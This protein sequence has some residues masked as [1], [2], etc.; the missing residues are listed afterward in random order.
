MSRR[1]AIGFL[2]ILF[3]TVGIL[4][5]AHFLRPHPI[6]ASP[7]DTQIIVIHMEGS[8]RGTENG[9][10]VPTTSEEQETAQK[11]IQYL[12]S[13]RERYTLRRGIEGGYPADWNCITIM[14]S[15]PDGSSRG[16]LLGPK[17]INADNVGI[18]NES[19]AASGNTSFLASFACDL[20]NPQEIRAF[21]SDVLHLPEGF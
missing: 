20:L 2:C 17:D 8:L 14:L 7:E 11:I 16:V 12:S 10:W 9:T 4:F 13:S 18:V 19:Y 3:C 21:V 1:D 6:V 5:I 15:F